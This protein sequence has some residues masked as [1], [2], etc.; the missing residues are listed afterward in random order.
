MTTLLARHSN[1]AA[2]DWRR[3]GIRLVALLLLSAIWY[4]VRPGLTF[5]LARSSIGCRARG[6]LF[7][8][9]LS[10]RFPELAG[11]QIGAPYVGGSLS[12][13]QGR[14]TGGLIV[15][16]TYAAHDP[17]ALNAAQFPTVIR[18]GLADEHF[19]PRGHIN[20]GPWSEEPIVRPRVGQDAN[21]IAFLLKYEY[22]S[23]YPSGAQ[24]SLLSLAVVRI[25]GRQPE[26]T[27]LVAVHAGTLTAPWPLWV[28]EDGDGRQE[29]IIRA[30]ATTFP[31]GGGP[32][33]R[34]Q[35]TIAVFDLDSRDVPH[36]RVPATNGAVLLWTPP[37]GQPVPIPE[38]QSADEFFC[39]LLPI[40][41]DFGIPASQ[42]ATAPITDPTNAASQPTTE[43]GVPGPRVPDPEPSPLND[44]RPF[45]TY[46]ESLAVS[47]AR[48][49]SP[50]ASSRFP[51]SRGRVAGSRPATQSS[52]RI[53]T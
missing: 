33:R 29:V 13:T 52:G 39:S 36:L 53:S 5:A 24:P 4:A 37:D 45:A 21:E 16:Q 48:S 8:A 35:Q 47:A 30:S 14:S 12:F 50:S 44:P 11:A 43:Q 31:R 28:D 17:N 41:D 26:L 15:W 18:L 32:G 49:A 23:A 22:L 7:M 20:V 51:R 9:V 1:C 46:P 40:P 34:V 25:P 27:G 3:L 10:R 38:H 2:R 42:P 19:E 6:V